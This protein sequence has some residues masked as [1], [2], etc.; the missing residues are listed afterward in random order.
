VRVW[1]PVLV[2]VRGA[3]GFWHLQW[4]EREVERE[5]PCGYR[6]AYTSIDV[7]WR[8][9]LRRVS[10]VRWPHGR[11]RWERGRKSWSEGGAYSRD[12]GTR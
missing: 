10:R 9:L 1:E 4:G 3:T 7:V 8:P 2:G 5:T 12:S 11:H 6:M